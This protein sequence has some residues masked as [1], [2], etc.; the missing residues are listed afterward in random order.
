MKFR[1]LDLVTDVVLRSHSKSHVDMIGSSQKIQE[2]DKVC[3]E[4]MQDIY[5]TDYINFEVGTLNRWVL[6]VVA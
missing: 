4:I 1:L 3:R 2:I 6:T 5:A